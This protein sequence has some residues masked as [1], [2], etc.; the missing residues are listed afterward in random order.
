[1]FQIPFLRRVEGEFEADEEFVFVGLEMIHRLRLKFGVEADE[2]FLVGVFGEEDFVL[3]EVGLGRERVIQHEAVFQQHFVQHLFLLELK[4]E[5]GFLVADVL[6]EQFDDAFLILLDLRGRQVGNVGLDAKE[7]GVVER[8]A[9]LA[10]QHTDHGRNRV[11]LIFQIF[12]GYLR[13][14]VL[15]PRRSCASEAPSGTG[16]SNPFALRVLARRA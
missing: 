13:R 11:A 6:L 9:D 5:R 4:M 1:M 3:F 7:I 2:A 12:E 8:V 16:R 10:F 14:S 15:P